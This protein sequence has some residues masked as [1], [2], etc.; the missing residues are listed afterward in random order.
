MSQCPRLEPIADLLAARL[1]DPDRAAVEE[2][3]EHCPA[4]QEAMERLVGDVNVSRWQ[5][6]YAGLPR[7]GA[8]EVPGLRRLLGALA[9]TGSAPTAPPSS[10]RVP[11][12]EA[13]PA[14]AGYEILGELGRGGM[15]V[16]YKAR[17]KG[18]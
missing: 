1:G 4:C 9:P 13:L 10:P 17:Q 3:I 6:L 18:L 5:Q 12:D 14:V 8:A 2:H 16:V 11:A 7:T 15:G